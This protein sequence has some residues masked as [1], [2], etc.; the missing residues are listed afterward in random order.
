MS[1]ATPSTDGV[2]NIFVQ[3]YDIADNTT[4]WMFVAY[5]LSFGY[6]K[7]FERNRSVEV[8]DDKV[9]GRTWTALV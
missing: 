2:G 1:L 3:S 5:G 9:S 4:P 7:R 8:Q 6:N